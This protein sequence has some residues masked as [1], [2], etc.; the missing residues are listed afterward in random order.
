[1]FTLAIS[2]LAI[3]NEPRFMDLTFQV[4]MQYCPLQH[5]TLLLP[6]DAST[7]E[8]HF[9]FGPASSFFL[10]VFVI[11]LFFSLVACWETSNL[12]AHHPV[13]YLFAFSY[14]SWGSH[15]K[16]TRVVCQSLLKWNTFCQFPDQGSNPCLLHW[17]AKS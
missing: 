7:T 2:C 11:A 17:K 13:S 6:P 3:S 16:N 14:S 9:C 4:P 1:M 8:C 15:G 12:G 5:Q 10:G